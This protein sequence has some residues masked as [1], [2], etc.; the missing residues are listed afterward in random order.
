MVDDELVA[1][2]KDISELLEER[3][4]ALLLRMG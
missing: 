3:G 1:F 2:G 4:T